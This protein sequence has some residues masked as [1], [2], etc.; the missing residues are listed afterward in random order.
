MCLKKQI[1]HGL[2]NFAYIVGL[3]DDLLT[4]TGT[5]SSQKGDLRRR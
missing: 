3:A 5:A 4:F 2:S 1:K